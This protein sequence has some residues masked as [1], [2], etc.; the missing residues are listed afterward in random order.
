MTYLR[1]H[2]SVAL[3]VLAASLMLLLPATAAAHVRVGVG[4]GFFGPVYPAY[5]GP[6]WGPYPYYPAYYGPYYGGGYYGG[7]YYGY[8]RYR[9]LGEVKIK[10]PEPD[11]RIYINGSLAGRAHDLKHFYLKPGTYDVEQR[12]DNDVQSERIYVLAD[13]T[14]KIEFGHPGEGHYATPPPSDHDRD[15]D[16]DRDHH[17]DYDDY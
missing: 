2:S 15:Y 4:F 8:P 6:Y 17:R 12:I 11:A 9:A 1:K 13:R 5:Y 7:G 14:V 16:R 10:S 3:V